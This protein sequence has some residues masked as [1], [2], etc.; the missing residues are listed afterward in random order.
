MR[1]NVIKTPAL[2]VTLGTTST[3]AAHELC[4]H[5]LSLTQDDRDC[6]SIVTIDTDISRTDFQD[7]RA[8]NGGKFNVFPARIAVPSG[9]DYSESPPVR[10]Q[11]FIPGFRPRYF[12][13]GAGAMRNNGHVALSYK[14]DTVEDEIRN[15]LGMLYRLGAKQNE[16]RPVG[17]QVYVVSF[18]GG[19]TGSGIAADIAVIVRQM[20]LSDKKDQRLMLFG[21]LPG[22]AMP[23]VNPNQES[24]RRS[25]STAALLEIMA[26]GMAA[27]GRPEGYYSKYLLSQEYQLPPRTAIFNEVYLIGRTGMPSV[28]DTARIVGLDLFQRIIDGTSVG[29]IE[30]SIAP[31]RAVLREFDDEGL[32]TNFSASCPFEVRFPVDEAVEAFAEVAASYMLQSPAFQ[33]TNPVAPEPTA[34]EVREWKRKWQ[35]VAATTNGIPDDRTISRPAEFQAA[36]FEDAGPAERDG[37]WAR[38]ITNIDKMNRDI[39]VVLDR[40]QREENMRINDPLRAVPTVRGAWTNQRQKKILAYDM[41]YGEYDTELAALSGSAGSITAPTRPVELERELDRPRLPPMIE[42]KL[43][44]FLRRDVAQ[45][46][47]DEYNAAVG[48]NYASTRSTRLTELLKSLRTR[49]DELRKAERDSNQKTLDMAQADKLRERG[50]ARAAW[51]GKLARPHPHQR[52][53]F[54][55]DL[56]TYSSDQGQ[57]Y[58][59][60]VEGVFRLATVD[61]THPGP[62]AER[63][64][65]DCYS[66][67]PGAFDL[68]GAIARLVPECFAFINA[69]RQEDDQTLAQQRAEQAPLRV[70]DFFR[71]RYREWFGGSAERNL[72]AQNMFDLLAIGAAADD[73][74]SLRAAEQRTQRYFESHLRHIQGFLGELVTFEP[75]LWRAGSSRLLVSLDIGINSAAMDQKE[76]FK[77]AL[78]SIGSMTTRMPHPNIADSAD[79]HRLQVSYAQHGISIRTIPDFYSSTNSSM[80]HYIRHQREWFQDGDPSRY[81][82]NGSPIHSSGEMQRL[83]CQR[84]A[85]AGSGGRSLRERVLRTQMLPDDDPGF[86]DLSPLAGPPANGASP[87]GASPYGAPGGPGGPQNPYGGG[88]AQPGYP[89]NYGAGYAAP[90]GGGMGQGAYG[91]QQPPN[92][93]G[94]YPG[95]QFNPPPGA[96][97]GQAPDPGGHRNYNDGGSL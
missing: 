19:G 63:T 44:G 58:R 66:R 65:G 41:L 78:A 82:R 42:E 14:L 73:R 59:V 39:K 9:I 55:L 13:Y 7:F 60:A 20:L 23:G 25:N 3:M 26:T 74:I 62:N 76:I 70:V 93:G 89:P 64:L 71:E 43:P 52:H 8:Q 5:L 38:V 6:V 88:G 57:P 22:D 69:A 10:N 46:V 29:N 40:V 90:H 37:L 15:A 92:Q 94:Y 49:V 35:R 72:R 28:Q 31:D 27:D 18:L 75:G 33:D 4:Y 56:F 84:D 81:G 17:V 83:V 12:D 16:Q 34:D 11:T 97:P 96:P 67:A 2:V 91:S 87:H 53:L 61:I 45:E 68:Q 77:Q 85:L 48:V 51:Q 54:D 95:G 50:H 36:A 30:R 1:S 47:A 21:I 79:L 32:P 86:V 24:W 80:E